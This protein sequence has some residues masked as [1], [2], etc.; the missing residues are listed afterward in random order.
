VC[1]RQKPLYWAET[2]WSD[3]TTRSGL[4]LR[5]RRDTRLDDRRTARSRSCT[6][7]EHHM[8][9]G[10]ESLVRSLLEAAAHERRLGG[11]VVVP[12]A[13]DHALD[14]PLAEDALTCNS[15]GF[16][17]IPETGELFEEIHGDHAGPRAA[18]VEPH[19]PDLL[20]S[21]QHDPDPPFGARER[22]LEPPAVLLPFYGSPRAAAIGDESLISPP[23][24]RLGV[25]WRCGAQTDERQVHC[26]LPPSPASGLFLSVRVAVTGHSRS[27]REIVVNRYGR[28]SPC[29][30]L[31]CMSWRRWPCIRTGRHRPRRPREVSNIVYGIIVSL[32]APL[33]IR[34]DASPQIGAGHLM[35][36]IALAQAWQT[37]AGPVA[38]AVHRTGMPWR[39][40][41]ASV[42]LSINWLEHTQPQREDL[43]ATLA[44]AHDLGVEW[45]VLD[46]YHFDPAYQEGARASGLRLLVIDD[47]AHQSR[48]S[49][50]ILLNQNL[51]AERLRYRAGPNTE[52]LLGP[53][54]ALLRQEFL[55][56][57]R[58]D[59]SISPV[60]RRVLV[61]M[62][63]SDPDNVTEAIVDALREFAEL[64]VAAILGAGH[65]RAPDGMTLRSTAE[66][67]TR[68]LR[69]VRN[70]AEVMAWADV[71]ISA[72][73]S[74]VLELAFMGLPSLL[75]TLAANQ[76]GV[77]A[78]AHR[79]G[80]AVSLAAPAA[81]AGALRR[82]LP[83]PERRAAMSRQGRELVDGEGAI[84]VVAA[85]L[86]EKASK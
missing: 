74:T 18:A 14:A 78:A 28:G 72:S 24:H 38:F 15:D 47:V 76:E 48:Y 11:S 53:R 21:G 17:T 57:Q 36:C 58:W 1:P 22:G 80:V 83:D 51:D 20:V 84:R 71:A 64:D 34:V 9:S 56:W 77:A 27:I 45:L 61:T 70:M 75:L 63:G 5:W 43:S 55:G 23:K 41:L 86:G 32:L 30:Q 65:P 33:L 19:L 16:A 82:L 46:G 44:L 50:D 66:R 13:R 35:R 62:G 79:R 67:G 52:L 68:Y 3:P 37:I 60:A 39:D 10:A 6:E 25:V 2:S 7:D 69:D 42:G 12:H 54:Y 4:V 40:R 29:H 81:I 31:L 59:R 26:R 85:M 49:A 73:G 8:S